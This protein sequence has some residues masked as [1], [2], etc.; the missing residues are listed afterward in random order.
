M[1][2]ML[3]PELAS[4]IATGYGATGARVKN[5]RACINGRASHHAV[6]TGNAA[7]STDKYGIPQA[8]LI[9]EPMRLGSRLVRALPKCC[10]VQVFP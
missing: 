7:H 6:P 9:D 5:S 8:C 3:L 4:R 2:S 1:L 10:F